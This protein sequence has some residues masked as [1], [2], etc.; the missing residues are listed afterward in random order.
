[1]SRGLK[2]A[3]NEGRR[4]LSSL[5]PAALDDFGLVEATRFYLQ[6]LA[7]QHGWQFQLNAALQNWH[8]PPHVEATL[9]RI[10]QQAL[11]NVGSHAQTESVAVVLRLDG[12]FVTAEVRDWGRGFDV[13]AQVRRAALGGRLGL[14]GMHDR[15][16]MLAGTCRIISEPGRGTVVTATIP[17]ASNSHRKVAS[18]D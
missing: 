6:N 13:E 14:A 11:S 18:N 15:A 3:I 2:E 9:F 17:I 4:L 16:R 1:M 10:V 8:P 5:R 12:G 7:T